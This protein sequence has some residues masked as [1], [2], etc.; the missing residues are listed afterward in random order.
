MC[1]DVH[2]RTCVC[3]CTNAFPL[4]PK[5]FS[6]PAPKPCRLPTLSTKLF[7]HPAPKPCRLPILST[8][9][10][11]HPA[12]KPCRLPT[13]NPKPFSVACCPQ[14]MELIGPA[15]LLKTS[16]TYTT[17]SACYCHLLTCLTLP[18]CNCHLLTCLTLLACKCHLL[19]CLTLPACYCHLLTCLLLPPT[20]LP[21]TAAPQLAPVLPHCRGEPTAPA[22]KASARAASR[23]APMGPSTMPRA[24][25]RPTTTAAT[26]ACPPFPK[27]GSHAPWRA[28]RWPVA[29]IPCQ[30][31]TSWMWPTHPPLLT[32]SRMPRMSRAPTTAARHSARTTVAGPP[33]ARI[34]SIGCT[35]TTTRRPANN[36]TC[37]SASA[38]DAWRS[39]GVYV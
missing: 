9:L 38:R 33:P 10:F 36:T 8:K 15:G 34:A 19:T 1:N 3:T 22:S 7:S 39:G 13:L 29:P 35:P 26:S 18:A 20:H 27:A 31:P 2:A 4:N 12:P 32:P 23:P 24:R 5:P 37:M 17:C 16:N 6:P 30:G 14:A 28:P 21:A 25:G 11:S